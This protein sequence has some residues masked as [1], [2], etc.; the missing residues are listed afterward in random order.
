MIEPQQLSPPPCGGACPAPGGPRSPVLRLAPGRV[1]GAA[2]PPWA[3]GQSGG[4]V[5][6]P[7]G[8]RWGALPRGGRHK[9]VGISYPCNTRSLFSKIE[10]IHVLPLP[11]S[12][13]LVRA[14][15]PPVHVESARTSFGQTAARL[16]STLDV[17]FTSL[18]PGYG[19]LGAR[20]SSPLLSRRDTCA[21]RELVMNLCN[22]HLVAASLS[23][24]LSSSASSWSVAG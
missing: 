24:G 10:A 4:A 8:R 12:S 15:R 22:R 20:A 18:T 17:H 13:Y 9:A 5:W 1:G 14:N 19:F 2:A 11:A 21:P 23:R 16:A 7:A 3:R 6:P